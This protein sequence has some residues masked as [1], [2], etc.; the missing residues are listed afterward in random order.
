MSARPPRTLTFLK[1][2]K[3]RQ[4][5]TKKR[6][7]QKANQQNPKNTKTKGKTKERQKGKKL[8]KIDLSISIVF[9]FILFSRFVFCLSF[10]FLPGK[11]KKNYFT[12]NDPH[13]DIYTF[14]YWQIF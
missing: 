14:S 4:K 11:G 6:K 7:N 13:H 12:S 2:E 8:E 10:V 1:F 3:T 5:R 9:A